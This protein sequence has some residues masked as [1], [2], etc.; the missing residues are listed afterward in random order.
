LNEKFTEPVNSIGIPSTTREGRL[1][2]LKWI[3]VLTMVIDHIGYLFFPNITEFR[4]IGRLA[5]PIFAYLIAEGS[6]RTSNKR[7]YLERLLLFAFISQIP[8]MLVFQTVY[9][10][11]LFTLVIGLYFITITWYHI[12]V[13]VLISVFLPIDYEWWGLV[14]PAFFVYCRDRKVFGFVLLSSL[15]IAYVLSTGVLVQI[16]A[17]LGI[18]LIFGLPAMKGIQIPV[19]NRWFFYWFYPVHLLLIIFISLLI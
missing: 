18:L 15:T 7:K 19:L 6:I 12:V 5:F 3:A 4:M 11:I 9:P 2:F 17:I 14:L 16:F 10:N 13:L 8:Y 1:D